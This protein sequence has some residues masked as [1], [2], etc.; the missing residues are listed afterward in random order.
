MGTEV[1]LA[2]SPSPQDGKTATCSRCGSLEPRRNSAGGQNTRLVSFHP[3][4][5]HPCL[6]HTWLAGLFS[7][8]PTYSQGPQRW[9]R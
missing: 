6:I 2:T 5:F 3:S 1:I 9:M 7:F 8:L 4:I